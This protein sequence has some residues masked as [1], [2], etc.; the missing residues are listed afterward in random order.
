MQTHTVTVVPTAVPIPAPRL[1][2][3]AP[4]VVSFML[5]FLNNLNTSYKLRM[6]MTKGVYNIQE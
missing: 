5:D 4:A 6:S 1:V 3:T 2:V